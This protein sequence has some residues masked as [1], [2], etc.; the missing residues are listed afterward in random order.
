MPNE[1]DFYG[2]NGYQGNENVPA[3]N[4]NFYSPDELN[5]ML[6]G[7]SS[8][9]VAGVNTPQQ[10]ARPVSNPYAAEPVPVNEAYSQRPAAPQQPDKSEP[11][12]PSVAPKA[13][14]KVNISDDD[15]YNS[16]D[17]L[18]LNLGKK[19]GSADKPRFEVHIDDDDD[20][21][22]YEPGIYEYR[23][24]VRV[25]FD[26]NQVQAPADTVQQPEK[27]K[28]EKKK[29]K[30]KFKKRNGYHS[31]LLFFVIVVVLTSAVSVVG[32][33]CINDILAFSRKEDVVT[34]TI[35]AEAT[36]DQVIDILADSKLIKQ[37]WFC[38]LYNYAFTTL[39]NKAEK[40]YKGGVYYVEGN[41][42][43][44][45]YLNEFSTTQLGAK[46]Y[47][48]T[49]PEGFSVF[50]IASRLD[51]FGICDQSKFLASIRGTSFSYS[52][53][54]DINQSADR[55]FK[56]E[57]Y[58]YP[59]TYE[60]YEGDD[61]NSVIRKMLD[62]SDEMW[63]DEYQQRA[64]ELGY[65]RDE[66][67]IIASI[68]QREAANVEQM[69]EISSVLHNRL[70]KPAT[71]PTIDCDSTSTYISR[72]VSPNVTNGES[73]KYTSAYN[74]YSVRGLPPGPI[75]NPGEDAINAALYP[76]DT[77]YYFF[78]HDNSGKIYLAQTQAE[79]D[80]NA[81]LVL[82]ANKGG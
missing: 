50:Q 56:L 29:K 51:D 32:I 24:P 82:K 7:Y 16:P 31:L 63:T 71:W 6:N 15:Y 20:L 39:L 80:Q 8:R 34:V 9:M 27:Q 77:N 14:F 4:N 81:N 74:T 68:I 12:I 2:Y 26:N 40:E 62:R 25:G 11:Q 60:F 79:H 23:E 22:G 70:S 64:D 55:T 76:S 17:E 3:D 33:S 19:A 72:Y 36:T 43:F 10:P 47:M 42:G 54:K 21:M 49:I 57:G 58:L 78:R 13:P 73:S 53:I 61:P 38:R 5:N 67:I 59:D 65:S 28:K 66:I 18:D 46:T 30:K 75:C 52:F 45:G 37:P 44:E 35:P 69:D 48:V 41:L 1:N